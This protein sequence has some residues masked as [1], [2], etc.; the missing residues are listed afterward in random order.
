[1]GIYVRK[2][3]PFWWM[4]IERPGQRALQQSTLIPVDGGTVLQTKDNRKLAQAIYAARMGDLARARHDLPQDKPV[5]TFAKY[6][7]WYAREVTAPK[8]GHVRER[9]ML[10]QLGRFFD[11]RDLASLTKEDGLEWRRKR[12]AAVSPGTVNREMQIMKRLLSTAVPT[13]LLAN[14]W[15]RLPELQTDRLETRLLEDEEEAR[16]LPTLTLEERALVLCALDTL[17][18][19]STVAAV[20]W[21]QDHGAHLTVLRPKGKSTTPYRVPVSTRLREALDA[22]RAHQGKAARDPGALVFP[23]FRSL[24][25]ESGA[26]T[27]MKVER[28]FEARCRAAEIPFG[29]KEG[30]LT[31]HALRH[32]GASRM[33]NRGVDIK[34]VAQIGNWKNLTVLERYLHPIGAALQEAVEAVGT[35]PDRGRDADARRKAR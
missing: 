16:L 25:D 17:Q 6:R 32:T 34:T 11:D 19:L 30:G 20:S 10:R 35:K 3:S 31:F 2:D 23:S 26:G 12:G 33:L 18:R 28:M 5:I 15:L 8:K 22:L 27:R 4:H 9:S 7:E 14:P 1:M 24:A 29:R 21:D 13:Y